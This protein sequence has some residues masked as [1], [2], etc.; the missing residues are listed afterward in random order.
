MRLRNGTTHAV[1]IEHGV[2]SLIKPMSD[3]EL[4]AKFRDQARGVLPDAVAGELLATAWNVR[5]QTDI[6]QLLALGALT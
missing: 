2:G 3:D 1:S 4:S 6:T 5:A